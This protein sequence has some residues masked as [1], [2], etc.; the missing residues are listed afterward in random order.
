M[1]MT[2]ALPVLSIEAA[3]GSPD[4][5]GPSRNYAATIARLGT[6][7]AEANTLFTFEKVLAVEFSMRRINE[8]THA[9]GLIVRRRS[10]HRNRS[11]PSG[12]LR[13]I[14]I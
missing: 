1:Y 3:D 8:V 14:A 11:A 4:K 7:N 12:R 2:P 10:N 13:K 5:S 6:R 9:L